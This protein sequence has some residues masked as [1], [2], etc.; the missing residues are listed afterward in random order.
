[1]ILTKCAGRAAVLR[2]ALDSTLGMSQ[3]LHPERN[4]EHGE[5]V[6]GGQLSQGQ[7]MECCNLKGIG[8]NLLT[9][10]LHD[11]IH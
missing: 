10:G 8:D 3:V 5:V 4:N 9:K 6:L 7:R 11:A 1:M 2:F